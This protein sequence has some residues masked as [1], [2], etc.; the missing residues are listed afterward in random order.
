MSIKETLKHR[1]RLNRWAA[2]IYSFIFNFGRWNR[3][4]KHAGAYLRH[5]TFNISTGGSVQIGNLARLRNC[6]FSI[7]GKNCKISI[8]G[9]R[10]V[11]SNVSFCCEDNDSSIII[12]N[13]FTMEGGEIAA[14]EG[15]RVVI[16]H[17]CMFS[18]G[19]DIRNGDSHAVLDT[20]TGERMN[21]SRDIKIGNHVWLAR[22]VSVLKGTAIADHSIVGHSAVVTGKCNEP[23]S[24]YAGIPARKVKSGIDWN[25]FRN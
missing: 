20:T 17:D 9:G 1:P 13:D 7:S 19:I 15:C 21:S 12:G 11:I 2:A 18:A 16:G 3:R 24:A 22:H 10:T 8:G 23:Y 6:S 25:R 14:I 4:A 5:T